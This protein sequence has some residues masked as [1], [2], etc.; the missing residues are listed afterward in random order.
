MALKT[1][2]AGKLIP[3]AKIPDK[4]VLRILYG[5]ARGEAVAPLAKSAGISERT[6]RSVVLAVRHRLLRP[7]FHRWSVFLPALLI[8]DEDAYTGA[9]GRVLAYLAKCYF[10][11]SC[12]SNYQQGLRETR[13]CRSCPI[14]RLDFLS[15]SERD[16]ARYHIDLIRGFYGLLGI[17]AE[18][19]L[20]PLTVFQLRYR[21]MMVVGEA[22]EASRRA[23]DAMADMKD[24]GERSAWTLYQALVKELTDDP[25]VRADPPLTKFEQVYGYLSGVD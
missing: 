21:H 24:K 3:F 7:R 8:L 16:A 12:Q 6:C 20:P 5:F 25:L 22:F 10:N 23:P 15:E 19:H 2:K 11:R 13:A 1:D 4:A 9:M 17:R 18:T 14:E